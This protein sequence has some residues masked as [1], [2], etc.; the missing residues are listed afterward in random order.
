MAVAVG[1]VVFGGVGVLIGALLLAV[2]ACD[3]VFLLV[4]FTGVEVLAL[5]VDF[6][7][8]VFGLAA[9]FL[10]G[11][12]FDFAVTL[13]LT[14]TLGFA[15]VAVTGVFFAAFLATFLATTGVA[16]LTAA[17]TAGCF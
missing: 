1:A 12:G 4:V 9:V 7:E 15:F 11:V 10:T 3:A 2:L 16:R 17:F 6:G 14:A 8:G 13:V 5:V